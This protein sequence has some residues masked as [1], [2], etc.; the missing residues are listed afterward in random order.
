MPVRK[1]SSLPDDKLTSLRIPTMSL[2]LPKAADNHHAKIVAQKEEKAPL[3]S[4]RCLMK[5]PTKGSPGSKRNNLPYPRK[6]A[7][8]QRSPTG[9]DL[10]PLKDKGHL[11]LG[12]DPQAANTSP[13]P[14]V[15]RKSLES[16][17]EVDEVH[18]NEPF[19]ITNTK[20]TP[21]QFL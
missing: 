8:Q 11:E 19:N 13:G 5:A 2:N 3:I 16:L 21:S 18:L 1:S 7:A 9:L 17:K 4:D 15:G 10:S 14:S 12:S 6:P 20:G